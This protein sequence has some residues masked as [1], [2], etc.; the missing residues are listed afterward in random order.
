M[1]ALGTKPPGGQ[2]KGDTRTSKGMD[3]KVGS[4]SRPGAASIA[5]ETTAPSNTHT[6]DRNPPGDWLK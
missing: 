4:G 3:T 6:M 1:G 5:I 2:G